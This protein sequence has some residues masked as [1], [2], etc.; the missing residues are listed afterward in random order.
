MSCAIL[1]PIIVTTNSIL[2]PINVTDSSILLGKIMVNC[3]TPGK[4]AYLQAVAGGYTGTEAEFNASLAKIDE[5]T[6]KAHEHANKSVL[7]STTVA[8]TTEKDSALTDAAA[9]AHTRNYDYILRSP[10]GDLVGV[11]IDENGNV[12]V[13]HNLYVT[14]TG[15]QVIVEQ[16]LSK[17][18]YAILRDGA[19]QGLAEGEYAGFLV[20]LYNGLVDGRL[21][22]GRDGYA[23]VGDV[24]DEQIL[25]TR[26]TDANMVNAT[27][28]VWHTA[29]MKAISMGATLWAAI[30]NVANYSEVL[31]RQN[32]TQSPAY[33]AN[34]T[35]NFNNGYTVIVTLTGNC[36]LSFS[37]IPTSGQIRFL[38][39]TTG[40][41][42]VTWP[43]SVK[44]PGAVTTVQTT[45][46][47]G[48]KADLY[49][50]DSVGD[51]NLLMSNHLPAYTY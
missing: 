44:F 6:E 28:L 8:F 29:T 43:A 13:S 7:D 36:I 24:G 50:L 3:G 31:T 30:Q 49:I 16:I 34:L 38:I 46:S 2:L 4:S 39:K 48:T 14:G 11:T 9:K 32:T 47:S 37:N 41:Y 23:R 51:G 25:L 10:S 12:I 1:L 42:T 22:I 17:N 15:K 45:V 19:E 21:V 20:K 18:Q 26:D 27:P 5:T 35:V 33:N 40:V